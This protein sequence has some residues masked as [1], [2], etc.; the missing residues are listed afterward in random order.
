MPFFLEKLQAATSLRKECNINNIEVISYGSF[1]TDP[2]SQI[3]H[4]KVR[5]KPK[6]TIKC[7]QLPL[8]L[9]FGVFR[10]FV[11]AWLKTLYQADDP[12]YF[13][14]MCR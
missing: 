11:K 13:N 7:F 8:S 6:I 14:I 9:L 3:K 12:L 4:L 2:K 1:L 10:L 5:K